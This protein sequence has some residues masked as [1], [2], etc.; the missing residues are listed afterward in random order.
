MVRHVFLNGL[1]RPTLNPWRSAIEDDVTLSFTTHD[2]P[3]T[4]TPRQKTTT[5]GS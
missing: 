3:V 5:A 1:K 4:L 2:T